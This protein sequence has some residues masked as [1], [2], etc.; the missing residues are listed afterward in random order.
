MI[1]VAAAQSGPVPRSET[2]TDAVDRLIAM[3]REA[4]ARGSDVVVFTECALTAFFPHWWI[5]D[6]AELDAWFETEMPSAA[7]QPLFDEAVRLGIGFHLGY[8]ELVRVNG[9]VRHFNTAV[10]VG[11]DGRIVGSHRKI[12]LPGHREHRPSNPFQ[13][14]EK[15]Y[16]DVG[17]RGFQTWDAFGGKLGMAVCN[18]RRW[19]ET[20]RML[21]LAGAEMTLVGYNTPDHIP[22]RPDLDRH[23]AFHHELCMQAGAQQNG[24]WVVAV[25]KAGVEEGVSQIGLSSIVAP[26]GEIVAQT[27]T[28]DD[29]VIVYA[30]D[31]DESQRN[32]GFF[33]NRRPEFYGAISDVGVAATTGSRAGEH[34]LAS[35]DRMG[36]S[37]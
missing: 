27:T 21:G 15:R 30:C 18:D 31:L 12:H 36:Q 37:R 8:A 32:R 4:H 29:E 13:N 23:V 26:T 10:L 25:G 35:P 24:M 1:T 9:T 22:D 3:M 33:A 34:P 17:D 11:R 20:Y 19:P 7:T 2:R 28:L 5:D 16:F 6:P 14:L